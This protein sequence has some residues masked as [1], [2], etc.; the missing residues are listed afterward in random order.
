MMSILDNLATTSQ[1][2]S[3]FEKRDIKEVCNF[4]REVIDI[5]DKPRRIKILNQ[6]PIG[7]S[8]TR[9]QLAQETRITRSSLHHHLKILVDNG[10]LE[11]SM[12]R[13]ATY[14]RSHLLNEILLLKSEGFKMHSLQGALAQSTVDLEN[15]VDV[16]VR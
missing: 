4:L 1:M 12:D 13:P 14:R 9:E 7:T 3:I 6:L 16:A 5:L 8:K 2:H 11:K 10:L 15:K